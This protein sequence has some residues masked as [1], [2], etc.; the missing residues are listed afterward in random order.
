M[1][2]KTITAP[3]IHAALI[4]AR[5]LLGDDVVLLES[6]PPENGQFARITVMADAASPQPAAVP[7]RT[8]TARQAAAPAASPAPKPAAVPA[9]AVGTGRS[10]GYGG[11]AL[12]RQPV[13][14]MAEENAPGAAG[15]S[16]SSGD[17]EPGRE[18]GDGYEFSIGA[19]T[20]LSRRGGDA[21]TP[22]GPRVPARSVPG[23]GSLFPTQAENI[24]G[25][26]LQV[27]QP[28]SIEALENLLQAQL[29][30][31]H[32]R[33]DQ[34][35]RR[36]DGAI[37]GAAQQ[38]T[39]HPLF[40]ALLA[41]GMRPATVTRLFDALAQKGYQPDTEPEALKWAAAQEIRRMLN[42]TTPKQ[43]NGA[44]VFIGPSGSG[45][46]SLLLKLARHNGFYARHQ[47]AIIVILPE[48]DDATFYQSPVDLFRH[49]G[50][51]VT[52]VRTLDEMRNAILRVQHFD[53]ILIDTPP[54][55]VHEAAA[56]KMLLYV[57]RLVDPIMPL[58]VQFVLNATRSIEDF[59]LAYVQR[60]PLRPD[61]LALTH[62]DETF[63]WGRVAEWLMALR[64]PVQFASTSPRVPDGVV[65]F[66]ATWFVEEMMKL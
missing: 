59:D 57:K 48:E 12:V 63:G 23:R 20:L 16:R 22:S 30:L 49:H 19:R 6:V 61:L 60:L 26:A 46:T 54:M 11:T 53:Q 41:Q 29:K 7:Q 9:G 37:I 18:E 8:A 17:G 64:L 36:F 28:S 31:L 47:T 5:R 40:G 43:S 25:T 2:V 13:P 3:T 50:L 42:L 52:T 35:E 1:N 14:V 32:D 62:L 27:Q 39:V 24:Q 58:T 66:S 51:P 44:Q 15:F 55:P 45:K 10:F 34:M 21:G 56:R 65:A 38:W 4:E 33:L